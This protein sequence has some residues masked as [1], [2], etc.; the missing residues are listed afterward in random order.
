MLANMK[1]REA[2][3]YFGGV[4]KLARK[5]KI[6]RAAIYQW[7]DEPPMGRQWEMELL[8]GGKLKARRKKKNKTTRRVQKNLS[9]IAA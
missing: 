9:R 3:K 8:T 7:G 2:K 1:T 6:E 4:S 5:L